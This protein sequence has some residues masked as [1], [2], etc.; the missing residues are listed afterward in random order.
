MQSSNWSVLKK[1]GREPLAIFGIIIIFI[2]F[3]LAVLAPVI[4]THDPLKVDVLNRLQ[5]P[6]KE[7]FLGT[8]ELG[9]DIYSRIIF[10]T[11]KT[12]QAGVTIVGLAFLIGTSLGS[13]AGF[14]GGL[15][16]TVIMRAVDIFMSIPYLVLALAVAAALGPSLI[17]AV[18]AL[19]FAW[20]PWYT[21]MIRGQILSVKENDYIE[22]GRAVGASS[23]RILFR[24]ILPNCISPVIVLATLDMG[25]AII[26]A[27]GLSFIGVGAQPPSP[28]WGAML[29]TGRDYLTT[30]WWYPI[31]PGL[32]LS[33][34]VLGFNLLGDSFRDTLDPKW[35]R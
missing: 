21:R 6:S 20:W 10:G 31:F 7:H 12:L 1:L 29:S 4:S 11:R 24:H 22:G 3:L 32:T 5:G 25:M 19:S 8:D 13:I 2:F 26:M 15:I 23:T 27:A 18:I 34:A 14:F 33:L 17:H 35:R 9:R 28:E 30:A 16:E